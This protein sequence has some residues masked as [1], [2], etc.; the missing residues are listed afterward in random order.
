MGRAVP[1]ILMRE[2]VVRVGQLQQGHWRMVVVVLT[3]LGLHPLHF[4]RH[5]W[6]CPQTTSRNTN[7]TR[8]RT[9]IGGPRNSQIQSHTLWSSPIYFVE[10]D[11][12]LVM[13]PTGDRRSTC[14]VVGWTLERQ[15]EPEHAFTGMDEKKAT[16]S[17]SAFSDF[18]RFFSDFLGH[19][20]KERVVSRA[21]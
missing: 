4:G 1:S 10:L 12:K 7:P 14:G 3:L 5:N 16:C 8:S 19:S 17:T 15:L 13:Y 6:T 2:G 18:P 9:L 11:L 21:S 20:E